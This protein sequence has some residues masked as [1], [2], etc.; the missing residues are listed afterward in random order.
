[1]ATCDPGVRVVHLCDYASAYPGSFVPSLA[2]VRR[3]VEKRGWSFEAVF[4]EGAERTSWYAEAKADGMAVRVVEAMPRRARSRWV[5]TLVAERPAP[6][7]LHSHFAYWDV[8]AVIAGRS[9]GVV[10]A[11]WHR[12]GP[13]SDR[14][15]A[16]A[17]TSV[18]FAT[19]GRGV[20]AH[21]CVGPNVYEGALARFSPPRRTQLFSNAIDLDRFAAVTSDERVRARTRLELAPECVSL[22]TFVWDWERKGGSLIIDAMSHLRARGLKA[23]AIMV[24]G[25]G[26]AQEAARRAGLE[27]VVRCVAPQ[28][29]VRD[30]YAAA[31]VF[32]SASSREGMPYAIL[33]ALACGIPVA[34]SD[35]PEHRDLAA[36]L[37]GC[38]LARRTPIALSRTL[39]AI[40]SEDVDSRAERMRRSRAHLEATGGIDGWAQRLSE[41]Y[42]RLLIARGVD[43]TG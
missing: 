10:V 5:R 43:A 31:D 30:L 7:V 8:P 11:V 37:P 39:A 18:R 26:L 32:V 33:E 14:F 17:R 12:H 16:R 22:V 13:L 1:M 29:D 35:I 15:L 4:G 40:L 27:D 23:V 36:N 9:T 6:T 2:A 25:E 24:G 38:S 21:L 20:D 34:A 19:V 28:T 3:A 42:E 41:T